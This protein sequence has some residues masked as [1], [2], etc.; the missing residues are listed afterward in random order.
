MKLD[1]IEFFRKTADGGFPYRGSPMKTLM[2]RLSAL[3][4]CVSIL[5]VTG[6]SAVEMQVARD[7]AD[8]ARIARD[9][10]RVILVSVTQEFCPYCHKIKEEI[11]KP[12]LL[13]GEYEDKVLIR[14]LSIDPGE[15]VI[16]FDGRPAMAEHFADGYKVW[17]TPTLLFLGP[18]GAE[19]SPRMLGVQTVEMYGYYVDESIDR[20]LQ[21][22]RDSDAR[23][24]R[25]S[26]DDIGAY[27]QTWDELSH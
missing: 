4:L 11:L 3:L 16:D 12:M 13:S 27:P 22:L 6:A 26:A 7:F 24:Y 20:A 21:R 18:D 17:V 23:A 1:S 19:L 25:P 9:Q 14:E 10:N 8:L 15:T 2:R 5:P